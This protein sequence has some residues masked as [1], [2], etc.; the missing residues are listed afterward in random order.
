MSTQGRIDSSA[1]AGDRVT[2]LIMR[3]IP[4]TSAVPDRPHCQRAATSCAAPDGDDAPGEEPMEV[5][6]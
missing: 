6:L 1:A 5:P 4:L 2:T 3:I